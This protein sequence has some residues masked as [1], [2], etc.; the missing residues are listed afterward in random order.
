MVSA[1]Q[2]LLQDE[3]TAQ[4]HAN[5]K[6]IRLPVEKIGDSDIPMRDTRKRVTLM[7]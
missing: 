2:R 6:K 1:Y 5:T 7:V 4:K 3:S